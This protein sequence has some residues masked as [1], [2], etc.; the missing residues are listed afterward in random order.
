M[1]ENS[2]EL[3]LMSMEE[4]SIC[5]EDKVRKWF[6]DKGGREAATVYDTTTVLI[7]QDQQPSEDDDEDDES[8]IGP[9]LPFLDAANEAGLL[10]MSG[11]DGMSQGYVQHIISPDQI[12]LTINPGSTPMPRNIEGATLT[13]HSEC[14]ETKQKEVTQRQLGMH[15]SLIYCQLFPLY[16]P[17]IQS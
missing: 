7:E 16:A 11:P 5:P 8:N 9:N 17:L 1:G 12:H 14:P 15:H 4:D 6:L 13:I 10:L 3:A 2:P